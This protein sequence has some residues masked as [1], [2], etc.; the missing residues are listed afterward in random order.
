[1]SLLVVDVYQGIFQ[2]FPHMDI[3]P[4]THLIENHVLESNG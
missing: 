3:T 1:M 2:A 4:V